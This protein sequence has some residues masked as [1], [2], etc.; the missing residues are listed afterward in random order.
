[1]RTRSTVIALALVLVAIVALRLVPASAQSVSPCADGIA[2]IS[3]TLQVCTMIRENSVNR[4]LTEPLQAV[5]WIQDPFTGPTAHVS[6]TVGGVAYIFD[7]QPTRPWFVSIQTWNLPPGMQLESELV[8]IDKYA[9]DAV[10]FQFV[11]VDPPCN[12]PAPTRTPSPTAGL[13]PTRTPSVTPTVTLTA[14]A[15][16]SAT[17]TASPTPTTTVSPPAAPSPS[18]TPTVTPTVTPTAEPTLTPSPTDLPPPSATRE[19]TVAPSPTV[20]PTVAPSPTSTPTVAPTALASST[21][22]PTPA[23]GADVY[24]PAAYR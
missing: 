22:S 18:G 5:A 11:C 12:R 4:V 17:T 23:E 24:L 21:S 19:P 8:L 7:L 14:E 16:P 20:T 1:M 13:P 15:T 2:D 6:D 3:G 10:T 9:G